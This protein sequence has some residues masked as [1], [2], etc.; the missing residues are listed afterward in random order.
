LVF[1]QDNSN[2][3]SVNTASLDDPA[4]FPP[5]KHIFVGSRI[6]WFRTNDTLPEH[7]GY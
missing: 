4:G 7:A 5:R 6:P 1:R 3:V 2:E